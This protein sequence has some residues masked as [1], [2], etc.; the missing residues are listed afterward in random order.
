MTVSNI[1]NKSVQGAIARILVILLFCPPLLSYLNAYISIITSQIIVYGLAFI[2]MA[3]YIC[4]RN[5]QYSSTDQFWILIYIYLLLLF[6]RLFTDYLS[7]GQ[8]NFLYKSSSTV[9][10]FFLF[11][12]LFP[13][14]FFSKVR[15]R[16]N[17]IQVS[18]LL[19]IILSVCMLASGISIMSG[20]VTISND[21]RFDSGF[22]VFSIEYG[23]YGVSLILLCAS[24]IHHYHGCVKYE[25]ILIPLIVLGGVSMALAGSR[26]PFMALVICISF[27]FAATH[28]LRTS[29]VI[30]AAIIIA[31]TLFK[32]LLYLLNDILEDNGIT[33]F[34]RI[35]DSVFADDGLKNHTSG[36]DELYEIGIER[37][38]ENPLFGCSLFIPGRIYVHNIIIEQFMALGI[39]GGTIF[40]LINA[41]SFYR[42]FRIFCKDKAYTSICLLFTQFFVFGCLSCTI[43]SLPIYWLMLFLI[44]SHWNTY[45]IPNQHAQKNR[46]ALFTKL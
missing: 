2:I 25:L 41:I 10:F 24:L 8:G 27:W 9:L 45:I 33:S 7:T 13:A 38:L 16:V 11:P 36:R 1:E 6:C 42:T 34:N 39:L 28:K 32:D 22:G 35:L 4:R 46:S 37:F 19:T 12:I 44:N 5:H 15:F 3:Y 43:I 18:W 30:I 21:G 29:I 14:V 23:H 17:I 31:S 40:L 26:G 20:N